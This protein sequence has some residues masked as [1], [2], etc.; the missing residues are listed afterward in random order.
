[1]G[2]GSPEPIAALNRV[3]VLESGEPLVDIR[4]H[5]PRVLVADASCAYLRATAA[6]MVAAAQEG[7][8]GG[9]R[10]RVT[11]ALRTLGIQRGYY[12]AY[13][14]RLQEEHP[15]WP[16]SALR[17]AANRFFAPV[18]QPAPP[19]HCTGGAVDVQLVLPDGETADLTSPLE[20]W[21]AA[22]TWVSG[23]SA[24]ARRSRDM[25]VDA[26]LSVG[27]SNCRDEFWHY[28][29]GDSAWAARTGSPTCPYGLVDAPI[30]VDA[31]GDGCAPAS[32]TR[33]GKAAWRCYP[34]AT[35]GGH[36]LQVRVRWAAGREVTL[37]VAA[38]GAGALWGSADR[39]AWNRL[40]AVRDGDS[41]VA[42][43]RPTVD[44]LYVRLAS[45][46]E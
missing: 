12:E 29:Y 28:S 37:T 25:M 41:L 33:E 10:L 21:R 20:G 31:L 26:M 13:Y 3:K 17:R 46:D 1:M 30:E 14:R 39:A 32:V 11:T 34:V 6:T 9:H 44:C 8:P 18:D 2:P 45:P 38:A 23:L 22:P 15:S 43:L 40:E 4:N 24:A 35:D 19:G 5:C 16:R 7:L 36:G 27:F 42:T